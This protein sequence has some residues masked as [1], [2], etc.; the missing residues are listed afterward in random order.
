MV[1]PYISRTMPAWARVPPKPAK[2]FL[3]LNSLL[4]GTWFLLFSTL[5]RG[6]A[7]T[8]TRRFIVENPLSVTLGGVGWGTIFIALGLAYLG[9]I[10]A[11]PLLLKR[12]VAMLG[13]L[14]YAFCLYTF[15]TLNLAALITPTSFVVFLL[16][17]WTEI[18]L[19]LAS[20][21]PLRG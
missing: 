2:A 16:A 1:E 6:T 7:S 13:T 11:R 8:L 19:F 9:I 18:R 4:W 5:D 15:A 12:L 21:G 17:L 14:I 10:W 20:R 3:A